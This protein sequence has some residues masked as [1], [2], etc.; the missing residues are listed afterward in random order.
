MIR[1]S[2]ATFA[3]IAALSVSV[4][5]QKTIVETAKA[6][7]SFKTLLAAAEAAGLVEALSGPGPLTVLAPTDEAFAKLPAGTVEKLL[8]PEAKAD[9]AA[10]LKL[11]V[12]GAKAMAADVVKMDFADTL[13]GQAIRIVVSGDSVTIGG[14]KILKT[15]IGCSN[16]VIHVID[17]V[18]LP[19]PSIAAT[20]DKAGTFKT[21]LAAAKAAGLDDV[22]ANGAGPFTVFAPTDEAFAK[23]PAGTVESLLKPE[24]K[25]KL[26]AIL[27]YHVVA[28]RTL[29]KDV[30]KLTTVK[31]LNGKEAKIS[32]KDGGA[33]I[34]GAKIVATDILAGNGV[35][36]VIDAV[37]LP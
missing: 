37:I 22:L 19:L 18:M 7:G 21:L 5:A 1:K 2:L 27:K 6:A 26:V 32:V 13:N 30:V 3:F 20:A 31:T 24:N 14:A 9:L 4:V 28:G 35:V 8:K 17:S 10:I 29:A 11:H 34:D 36:H 25:E 23:L 15:D 33:M 12:I 16:G